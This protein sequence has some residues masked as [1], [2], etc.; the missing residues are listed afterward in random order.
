MS[1]ETKDQDVNAGEDRVTDDHDAGLGPSAEDM[2]T[3]NPDI[4]DYTQREMTQ[5]TRPEG[6]K[7]LTILMLMPMLRMPTRMI[8]TTRTNPVSLEHA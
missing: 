8:R 2:D 1:E 6:R 4:D 3:H 7:K 5:M